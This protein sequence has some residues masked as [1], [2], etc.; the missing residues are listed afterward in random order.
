MT[1]FRSSERRVATL[2]LLRSASPLA[3]VLFVFAAPVAAQQPPDRQGIRAEV[4]AYR[5]KADQAARV[6]LDAS[7]SDD[8]R[9]AAVSG[10]TT[11]VDKQHVDGA[12]AVFRNDR[13]SGRIRALALARVPHVAVDQGALLTDILRVAG[14]PSAPRELRQTALG[15]LQQML[16]S[17]MAAHERH[18]EVMMA[19][20]G[21]MQDPDR[22]IRETAVS[23]LAA[24]GDDA[25]RRQL[26]DG[27][28][29]RPGAL[30]PPDLSVR[31]LGLRPHDD[32]YPVLH[33]V[34][35]SAPDEATKVECVRL[36]GG[37]APSR[38]AIV[39]LLRN[40]SESTAV[41]Q[42]ALSTLNANDRE[43]VAEHALPIVTDEGADDALRVYA[44]L[45]VQ[46]R[47]V[48]QKLR[49]SGEGDFDRAVQKLIADSRSLAVREAAR[50]YVQA[51]SQK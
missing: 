40:P 4:D 42:A 50:R 47:R 8:E 31:L 51:I 30:L 12:L 11:F 17:S 35:L 24:Q 49:L 15:V 32:I 46:Q 21:L 23:I 22:A 36:L 27:L 18:H 48:S 43:R 39:G 2:R 44:V 34:M 10:I 29:S 7:K 5:Q 13:E 14:N 20:R 26:L 25:A 41:R 28:K 16:F 33:Q 6:F 1:T 38:T 19:L 37:Y 9:A 3:L 45:V